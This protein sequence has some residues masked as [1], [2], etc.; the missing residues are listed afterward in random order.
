[1]TRAEV[2]T[3]I[4]VGINAL[5]AGIA[6]GAGRI[7]EFNSNRVLSYPHI[8]MEPIKKGTNIQEQGLPY[9]EWNIVLHVNKKDQPDS[10]ADQYEQIVDE[11][12]AIGDELIIKLNEAVSGTDL[13]TISPITTDPEIKKNADCLTGVVLSFTLSAPSTINYC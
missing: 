11:C 9:Q 2:K 13:I 4:Q 5:D 6:Y 3:F 7:S 10:S 8:W 12:D 1:M